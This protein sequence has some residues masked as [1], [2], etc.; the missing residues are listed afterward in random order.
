MHREFH[1]RQRSSGAF[2]VYVSVS[3]PFPK[4]GIKLHF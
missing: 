3:T 1:H 2:T 4:Q